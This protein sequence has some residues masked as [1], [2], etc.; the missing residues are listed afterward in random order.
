MWIHPNSYKKRIIT[1]VY[2]FAVMLLLL[3]V[4]LKSCDSHPSSN[5]SK[6][7]VKTL[8]FIPADDSTDERITIPGI[9]GLYLKCGQLNQTVDF[10]NPD[11]NNC[12]FQIALYL[13]DDTL[14]FESDYIKPGEHLNDI[15]ISEPLKQGVYQNCTL[16]Y[17]CFSIDGKTQYNGSQ[18]KVEIN[19]IK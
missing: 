9:S 2:I 19:S 18:F 6:E 8:D 17:K 3:L 4:L 16:L 13:S 5:E 14:L 10:Y 7:E 12:L 11:K 1:V 15:A